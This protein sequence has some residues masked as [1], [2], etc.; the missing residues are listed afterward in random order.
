MCLAILIYLSFKPY[1]HNKNA[2]N[3]INQTH[4]IDPNTILPKSTK[5]IM[6]P[7]EIKLN[8]QIYDPASSELIFFPGK[9][10]TL[11][12][13][14]KWEVL[15]QKSVITIIKKVLPNGRIERRQSQ[16]CSNLPV[17]A[18]ELGPLTAPPIY[19][20]EGGIVYRRGYQLEIQLINQADNKILFR[21]SFF[22]GLLKEATGWRQ[23]SPDRKFRNEIPAGPEY[24]VAGDSKRLEYNPMYGVEPPIALRISDEV[25]TDPNKLKILCKLNEGTLGEKLSAQLHIISCDQKI[26]S[27]NL[28][29]QNKQDWAL[30]KVNPE[31]WPTGDYSIELY[32][33]LSKTV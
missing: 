32:P 22:Q 4:N 2:N 28:E 26:Y 20:Y 27:Q 25:L 21:L 33:I 11:H 23:G 7:V 16:L 1:K 5:Y 6:H 10:H 12:I 19:E 13:T 29:L 15:N 30:Y 9:P 8:D 24:F 31:K 14:P 17:N 3:P 18:F